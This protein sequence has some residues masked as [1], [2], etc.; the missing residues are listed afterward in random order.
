MKLLNMVAVTFVFSFIILSGAM[1]FA[2]D[3]VINDPV[4]ILNFLTDNPEA[5][6]IPLAQQ[7]ARGE[8][9]KVTSISYAECAQGTKTYMSIQVSNAAGRALLKANEVTISCPK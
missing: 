8:V 9:V 5:Q 7:L 3:K 6:Q 4:G 2:A 1:S